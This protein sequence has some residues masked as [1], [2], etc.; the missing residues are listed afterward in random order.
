MEVVAHHHVPGAEA[1]HQQPVDE[2]LSIHALHALVEAQHHHTI[3]AVQRQ[4][5]DLLAQPHQP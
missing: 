2:L 3:H 1:L 4:R 5:R